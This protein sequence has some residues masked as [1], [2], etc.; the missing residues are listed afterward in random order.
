MS[1]AT[2]DEAT[3]HEFGRLVRQHKLERL[4]AVILAPTVRMGASVVAMSMRVAG[5][6]L[7]IVIVATRA[8]ADEKIRQ[9]T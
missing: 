6:P 7:D 9:Y 2:A 5:S 8:E 3:I 1:Q 4:I